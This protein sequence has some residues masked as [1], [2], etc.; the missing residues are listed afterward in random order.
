MSQLGS[1]GHNT[2]TQISPSAVIKDTLAR[3]GITGF[4]R[5]CSPFIAGNALKAGTR[6][7][8]YESIRDL[9]RGSDGKMSTASNV[10][11]GVGAGCVESIVAVTPSE[12]I[13]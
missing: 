7:F 3:R 10:L 2:M 9:L 6:F 13:K 11:A 5:G 4:Y 12:A 8:T 1:G